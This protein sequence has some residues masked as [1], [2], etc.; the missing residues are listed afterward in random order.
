[1]FDSVWLQGQLKESEYATYRTVIG[2][3]VCVVPL[4]WL[5]DFI[6]EK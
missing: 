6:E 2:D 4:L 1:M 5:P 3:S